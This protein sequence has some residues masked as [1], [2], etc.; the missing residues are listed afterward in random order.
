MDSPH[1][2]LHDPPRSLTPL[3]SV[4]DSN[5]EVNRLSTVSL[6]PEPS[7]VDHHI[8]EESDLSPLTS[9]DEE[10]EE[11]LHPIEG[12]RV[13][14]PRI[15][16]LSN[17]AA[18]QPASSPEIMSLP[19]PPSP[20]DRPSRASRKRKRSESPVATTTLVAQKQRQGPGPYVSED[21]CHQCRNGPRYAFMR[22]TSSNDS[23]RSCRKLFCVSC[24][25]KRSECF[26]PFYA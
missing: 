14:R 5:E 3:S 12:G 11:I 20:V 25:I 17:F 2:I 15:P 7:L 24:I 21:R 26:S 19:S 4:A 10:E 6:T 18:E 13:L 22:C 9:S 16:R 23:G 8:D 1:A